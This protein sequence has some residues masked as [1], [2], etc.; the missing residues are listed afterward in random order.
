MNHQ[1]TRLP[2]GQYVCAL[3][4]WT[5]RS[6]PR[7]A[8]V[9]VPRYEY[10]SWPQGLYTATQLRRMH[11]K[12]GPEPDGYYPLVKAPYHRSLYDIT[13]AAPRRVP[14]D[15]QREAII[16][17]RAA[18]VQAYTCRGCGFYDGSH[19]RSRSGVRHGY[20]AACRH[21]IRHRDRQASICAWAKA[22]LDHGDF[23]VLGSEDEVIELALVHSSGAV[24]FSSLIQ[25]QNPQRPDLAT[26][27]HGI[28]HMMLADAPRFPDVWPLIT[29]ILRR[30]R[31]V[32]VYNAAFDHRLLDVTAS[33]YGCRVPGGVWEC[34][35]EQYAIFHGA[36]SNYHG[37]Y[38]W[39]SLSTACSCLG[40]DVPGASHRALTDALAALGV[41]QALAALDGQI[42][43]YP[44]PEPSALQGVVDDPHPF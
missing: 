18:L 27:I 42:E 20:C 7:S 5:W 23:I 17:M 12:P 36:W 11:L 13:K 32:L 43:L 24:L 10:G 14:T 37:S 28:T 31:C 3:C 15:K 29:T 25:P 38:T 6:P 41:L 19:G 26:H 30:Y 34:L 22:Y 40:V 21:E 1:L 4:R 8:C 35:M 44:L 39:Q 2:D 9:G 16:Q 33:R